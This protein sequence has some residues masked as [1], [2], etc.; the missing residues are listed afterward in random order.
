MGVYDKAI[1]SFMKKRQNFADAINLGLF[2]GR[3]VVQANKLFPLNTEEAEE[4][5]GAGVLLPEVVQRIR[6]LSFLGILDFII[7]R[8][9]RMIFI[10]FDMENQLYV[11][12]AMPIRVMLGD[13]L[14][15]VG[16]IQYL[17][18][19]NK[20][21]K[22]LKGSAEYLSGLR[23]EDKLYPVIT[24]CVYWGNDPWDGPRSLWDM[25]KTDDEDIL[26]YVNDYRRNLLTPDM[27]PEN[28]DYHDSEF[29]K[30]MR[31]LAAANQSKEE[32]LNTL[33]P[34]TLKNM[35]GETIRL[36]NLLM[37]TEFA[38]EEGE[39]QMGMYRAIEEIN[40]ALA[41]R[42]QQ[43]AELDRQKVE[44]DQQKVELDLKD[45]QILKMQQE[46]AQM[47]Q[48]NANMRQEITRLKDMIAQLI[49]GMG[50]PVLE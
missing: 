16:Q 1:K 30:L 5:F 45:R 2:R 25:L 41:E 10:I 50:S 38:I 27:I 15:Y 34:E 47:Q 8:D 48:D 3:K 18:E 39:E 36:M 7:M 42:D 9:D 28:P 26:R 43:K 32:W 23:P 35:E 19:N 20:K 13:A 29:W 12:Y 33:K 31:A 4:V 40:E 11:H 46:Y 14:R 22:Q 37:N 17:Q 6:D 21:K 49:A 24:L 44:L